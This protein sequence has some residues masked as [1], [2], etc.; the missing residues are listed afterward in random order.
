MSAESPPAERAGLLALIREALAGSNQDFTEGS[1]T[2][3]IALLA[4]PMVLEMSME[5]LFGIVDAFFVARLGRD[6]LATVVLT[7]SLLTVLFG[8]AIGLS[9]STT[10][11]VARRYGEKDFDGAARAGIQAIWIGV[12]VSALTA[13]IGVLFA[14]PVLGLM[15]ASGDIVTHGSIFTSIILGTSAVIF[16]LF[17]LNAVFRGAGDAAIAFRSLALANAINIVLEPCLIFGLGPF[18]ELGLAGAAIA[19]SIGRGTGVAYQLW[20]LF[21]GRGRLHVRRTQMA[22]DWP[23]MRNLLRISLHGILQLQIATASWLGLVR[24]VSTFGSAALAGYGLA[25]R[26]VVMALLPAWGMSNAAATLVGQNLGAGKPDRAE[27]AVWLTGFY[28]MCFLGAVGATFLIG[29]DRIM[30]LFEPEPQVIPRYRLSA[31]FELWILILRVGNGVGAVKFNGAGDTATPTRVNF[32]CYWMLQI[33]AAYCLAI[34]IAETRG[35][36]WAVPHSRVRD[37]AGQL[38]ALPP[39]RL[40]TKQV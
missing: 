10:A 32:S 3:A 19:T 29:A 8:I 30:A 34:V 18:P 22:A 5:S 31:H 15:G 27:R 26:T 17:L 16:L 12:A 40:K 33:P 6:A 37:G 28:N 25:L 13:V 23:V 14:K 2:R 20:H 24:I 7:E 35:V 11:V 4:I 9:M 21:S 1:L 36:F 38:L 39:G